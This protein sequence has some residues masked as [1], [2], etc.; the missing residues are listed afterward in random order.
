[1]RLFV[2]VD[3]PEKIQE[4]I[5]RDVVGGLR[6]ALASAKWTRSEG[7]HLTLRF[8]GNVDDDRV[9]EIGEALRSS[10]SSSRGFEA[11][12]EELGGFPTLRRPRVLW[13]GIGRG[14]EEL[15]ELASAVEDALQPL[16]FGG[17]DRP[18]H[19][20]FTLARFPATRVIES[21]PEVSVPA[22]SFAVDGVVLFRSLL[23]PKGARYTALT[24]VGLHG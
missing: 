19:P 15:V 21:M 6:D 10:L 3:V 14:R 17:E 9:D 20:H 13:V 1:M 23:H 8:L 4:R 22:E 18:F 16:G 5:E 2:A 11:A 24:R 12:F 7:R